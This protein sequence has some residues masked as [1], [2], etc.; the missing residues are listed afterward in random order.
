MTDIIN[1][2]QL[3]IDEITQY[4][5]AIKTCLEQGNLVALQETYDKRNDLIKNFFKKY[6]AVLDDQDMKFFS[7]VKKQDSKIKIVM[8]GVKSGVLKDVSIQKKMR[9]GIEAYTQISSKNRK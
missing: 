8:D 9:K 1:D 4:N 2:K 3:A 7:I 6:S 5:Q